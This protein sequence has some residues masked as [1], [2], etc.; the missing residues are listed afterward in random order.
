MQQPS[1]VASKS[2]GEK[3]SPLPLWRRI[4]F[5]RITGKQMHGSGLQIANVFDG[6]RFHSSKIRIVH[7]S[8]VP[9]DRQVPQRRKSEIRLPKSEIKLA[10][11][12]AIAR[13]ERKQNPT[14]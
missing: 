12:G 2:V 13:L 14:I 3:A 9:R 8:L 1:E 6:R 5:D 7:A 10:T 11:R 4:G